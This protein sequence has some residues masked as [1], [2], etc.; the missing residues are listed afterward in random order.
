MP[1]AALFV[2]RSNLREEC[3]DTERVRNDLNVSEC[4]KIMT[5]KLV[6]A[7]GIHV[8]RTD[9]VPTINAHKESLHTDRALLCFIKECDFVD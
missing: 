5:G 2:I 8:F 9:A 1:P 7:Y 6:I 3:L 4:L